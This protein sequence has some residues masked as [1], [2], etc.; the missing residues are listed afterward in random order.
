VSD[1]TFYAWKK[2]YAHLGVSE[3]RLLRQVEK[4]NWPVET[5]CRRPL[6][7]QAQAV[8]GAAKKV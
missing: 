1:A 4:E 5:A 7:R 2:K 6:A 8:G 3:L